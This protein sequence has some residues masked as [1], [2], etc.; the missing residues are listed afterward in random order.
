MTRRPR[1]PTSGG[2]CRVCGRSRSGEAGAGAAQGGAGGRGRLCYDQASCAGSPWARCLP[3]QVSLAP[4]CWGRRAEVADAGGKSLTGL[5]R[6]V[7]PS[8]GL[9]R[10]WGGRVTGYPRLP[11]PRPSPLLPPAPSPPHPPPTPPH[12]TLLLRPQPALAPDTPPT[13]T[14]TPGLSFPHLPQPLSQAQT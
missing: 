7:T 1:T 11:R 5:C 13:C 3:Q 8:A 14:P 12:L 6:L 4:L 10:P 9:C 2:S